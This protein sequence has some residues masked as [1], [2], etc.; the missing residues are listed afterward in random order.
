[1]ICPECQKD[2]EPKRPHQRFCSNTCRV[3]HHSA[4]DGGLRGAVTA[5]RKCKGDLVSVTLRFP[6]TDGLNALKLSPGDFVE[7]LK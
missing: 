3:D 4:N 6:L 7:V 5:V 1:M 2:F